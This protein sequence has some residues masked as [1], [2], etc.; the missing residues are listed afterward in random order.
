MES[1]DGRS[2]AA[3]TRAA[4][5]ETQGRCAEAKDS[6]EEAHINRKAFLGAETLVWDEDAQDN[7][8]A[9]DDTGAETDEAEDDEEDERENADA[10]IV[11]GHSHR[12]ARIAACGR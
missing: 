6:R 9:E 8:G 12:S 2:E 1:R 11:R 3:R 7:W 4:E 10:L 5:T